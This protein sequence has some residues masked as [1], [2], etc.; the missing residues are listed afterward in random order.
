[1][2]GWSRQRYRLVG[3][4][5]P[6]DVTDDSY[7]MAATLC[8]LKSRTLCQTP[9]W[10]TPTT[11][12]MALLDTTTLEKIFPTDVRLP[13]PAFYVELG[14]Q[15]LVLHEAHNVP[16]DVRM[17]GV[18]QCR[19][20]DGSG[21]IDAIL[22][23]IRGYKRD[24]H[25]GP[26][27]VIETV[28]VPLFPTDVDLE[29]GTQSLLAL[30]KRVL[31]ILRKDHPDINPEDAILYNEELRGSIYGY[32][33][34]G[35]DFRKKIG[36]L[37]INLILYMNSRRADIVDLNKE[38]A[39]RLLDGRP[40]ESLPRKQQEVVL[41]LQ[42]SINWAIGTHVMIDPSICPHGSSGET[43]TG[44]PLMRQSI[45]RGHWRWQAHGPRWS[46]RRLQWIHA[47]VRKKELSTPNLGHEYKLKVS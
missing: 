22:I 16:Y 13:F 11:D 38:R 5:P 35:D 30:R 4:E 33:Y 26:K 29:G 44:Q 20:Y 31:A 6:E 7:L 37:F 9:N 21:T 47:H 39:E 41:E 46:L 10:I 17:V 12:L 40:V 36:A 45:V 1:M 23:V 3:F 32:E 28:F 18:T 15:E 24:G 19:E 8:A 27:E 14:S 42:R 2:R 43:G 34:E 25:P